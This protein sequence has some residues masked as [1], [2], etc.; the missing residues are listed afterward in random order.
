[1]LVLSVQSADLEVTARRVINMK[2]LN[3]GQTCL[4]PD[5]VLAH[6]EICTALVEAIKRELSGIYPGEDLQQNTDL[7]RIINAHHVK[8]LA[9]LLK[10]HG[11]KVERGGHVDEDDRFVDFT[12][13]VD[14]KHDSA[15]MKEEIFGPIL[16]I[17]EVSGVDEAMKFINQRETPLAAYPFTK[18]DKVRD[19]FISGVPAGGICVNDCIYHLVSN[20][21][22]FGGKGNSGMGKYR[23]KWSFS[24]FSHRKPVAYQSM[25]FD[26]RA[27][28]PP[29]ATQNLSLIKR[30]V[31]GFP[32]WMTYTLKASCV[33]AL[34]VA[35]NV[36]LSYVKIDIQ[37]R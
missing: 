3:L 36:F 32:P 17:L 24:T 35:V 25:S 9:G 28:Y 30:V 4:S 21:L 20:D 29:F 10:D 14:P 23:G 15:L 26:P 11:G 19:R 5:Y 12:I 2:L 6:T 34:A 22:G 33:V 31:S 27:R 13:I 7:G 8:R 18:D 16:P 37:L 1:M